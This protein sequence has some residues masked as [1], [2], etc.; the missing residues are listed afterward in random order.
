LFRGFSFVATVALE[1][2]EEELNTV[3]MLRSPIKKVKNLKL[4]PTS[5]YH[6]AAIKRQ[7]VDDYDLK[8]EIGYGS[9]SVCRKCVHKTTKAEY[10]VK[11]CCVKVSFFIRFTTKFF[12]RGN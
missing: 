5:T 2:A 11:V 8:E 4:T 12:L 3:P 10:A 1:D 7:F 6:K 9:F